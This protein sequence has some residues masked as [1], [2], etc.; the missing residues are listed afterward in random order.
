MVVVAAFFQELPQAFY[1]GAAASFFVEV[2]VATKA[3]REQHGRLPELY[4][5]PA[6]LFFRFVLMIGAGCLA[7]WLG[8][9]NE[10][11]AAYIGA[12]A[13]A[14]FDRLQRS[15]EPTKENVTAE[16]GPD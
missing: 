8:S 2:G 7:A 5:R 12:S 10:L 11:S 6:F 1:I 16:N 4:K 13:P 3:C 15:A 14:I 9:G